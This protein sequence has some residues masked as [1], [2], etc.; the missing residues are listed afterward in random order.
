MNK[1]FISLIALISLNVSYQFDCHYFNE[2]TCGVFNR[3]FQH[4][5]RKVSGACQEIQ[6]DEGCVIENGQCKNKPNDN[7]P[8]NCDFYTL[9]LDSSTNIEMCK[10]VIVDEGCNLDSNYNCKEGT[11]AD[12]KIKCVLTEDHNRC[13]SINVQI[14]SP[15]CKMDNNRNCVPSGGNN[16]LESYE[17]CGLSS[18]KTKCEVQNFPCNSISNPDYCG[19][20]KVSTGECKKVKI[21]DNTVCREVIKHSS[22][23]INTDGECKI[24]Q[25]NDNKMC[26]FIN[27]YNQIMNCQLFEKDPECDIDKNNNCIDG[28]GVPRGEKCRGSE[29]GTQSQCR[30]SPIVCSDYYGSEESCK[31]KDNCVYLNYNCYEAETENENYCKIQ[32]DKTCQKADDDSISNT[33]KCT[34]KYNKNNYKYTCKKVNKDCGDYD[35]DP[36]KCDSINTNEYQCKYID[37]K[38]KKLISDGYCVYDGNNCVKKDSLKENEICDEDDYHNDNNNVIECYKREK[39]CSDIKDDSC[40]NYSEQGNKCVYF[41]SHCQEVEVDSQC[42]VN[43]KNECTGNGCSF[44]SE[45]EKCSYS[46]GSLLKIKRILS[47]AL[48]FLI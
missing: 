34:F 8:G 46:N 3:G 39:L 35:D 10:K 31:S 9:E 45:K 40:D 28:E 32:S 2:E 42:S 23:T 16:E 21:D 38:C 29:D 44:D 7:T 17:T 19:K 5:C 4:K 36:T 11:S 18:D 33:E 14:T 41:E 43:E 13:Q 20:G 15:K 24:T 22:C 27:S 25:A 26:Q 1:V 37:S 48:F 30:H 12:S 6:I 47:L